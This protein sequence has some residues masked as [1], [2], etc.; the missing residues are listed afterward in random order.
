MVKLQV[1]V[2]LTLS[3][4]GYFLYFNI[5]LLLYIYGIVGRKSWIKFYRVYISVFTSMYLARITY[6]LY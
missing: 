6:V 4:C 1:K 2:C 3:V 5:Y